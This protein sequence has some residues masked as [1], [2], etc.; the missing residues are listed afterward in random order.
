MQRSCYGA[1]SKEHFFVVTVILLT[2]LQK[3][4]Q[5]NIPDEKLWD[6]S[7]YLVGC[8]FETLR[9]MFSNAREIQV[10][11]CLCVPSTYLVQIMQDKTHFK[12]LHHVVSK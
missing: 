8:V 2:F 12:N 10:Q 1:H 7:N 11:P 4:L 9:K 5:D 3:Q 6:S